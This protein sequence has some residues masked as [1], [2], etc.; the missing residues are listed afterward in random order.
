[1]KNYGCDF[2]KILVAINLVSAVFFVLPN[3]TVAKPPLTNNQSL[4]EPASIDSW[5][6]HSGY[7]VPGDAP[8]ASIGISV[9]VVND[10]KNVSC[11]IIDVLPGSPAELAGLK[12]GM[13]IESID[14]HPTN[15]AFSYPI[16]N[17][18]SNLTQ[19]RQ[20]RTWFI[21]TSGT[22]TIL[23]I[24]KGDQLITYEIERT[25]ISTDSAIEQCLEA[26]DNTKD[27]SKLFVLAKRLQLL[28]DAKYLF[29]SDPIKAFQLYLK[30]KSLLPKTLSPADQVNFLCRFGQI[31]ARDL[32]A[33]GSASPTA[34]PEFYANL[35]SQIIDLCSQ[36]NSLSEQELFAQRSNIDSL[37]VSL[38]GLSFYEYS[39]QLLEASQTLN[40][41]VPDVQQLFLLEIMLDRI[42][43]ISTSPEAN[44]ILAK[45]SRI[46]EY[47]PGDTGN[48]TPISNCGYSLLKRYKKVDILQAVAPIIKKRLEKLRKLPASESWRW[49]PFLLVVE[50]LY[51][52]QNNFPEANKLYREY[53]ELSRRFPDRTLP[54]I[55]INNYKKFLEANGKPT[56]GDEYIEEFGRPVKKQTEPAF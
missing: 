23:K 19:P 31:A 10:R 6:P 18:W 13:Q 5:T 21:G 16:A 39:N 33:E 7:Y 43:D 52:D 27:P 17:A 24:R 53:F 4:Q 56:E 20:L 34:N 3:A 22:P 48:I 40:E 46:F 29:F 32:R 47:E 30:A 26:A 44:R 8:S 42:S 28:G 25:C 11:A 35:V 15:I 51:E 45:I 55:V 1:M 14:D 54:T 38:F 50:Q 37:A 2:Y 9:G 12:P 41:N 36:P 49:A